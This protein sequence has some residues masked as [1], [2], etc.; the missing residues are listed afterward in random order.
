MKLNRLLIILSIAVI[1]GAGFLGYVYL[2]APAH[3]HEQQLQAGVEAFNATEY[4]KAYQIWLPLAQ[5]GYGKAQSNISAIYLSG[6]G[7]GQNFLLAYVWIRLAEY[8]G[9]SNTENILRIAKA[10]LSPDEL[11]EAEEIIQNCIATH[12][13]DCR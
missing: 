1:L 12:Y 9:D 2:Y 5:D 3:K 8:N 13:K 6:H 4:K 10:N 11:M 7:T